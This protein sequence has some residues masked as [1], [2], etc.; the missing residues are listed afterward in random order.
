MV[1]ASSN[2]I[3][4]RLR[5]G[6]PSK[7]GDFHGLALDHSISLLGIVVGGAIAV[8]IVW[9]ATRHKTAVAPPEPVAPPTKLSAARAA[10]STN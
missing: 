2:G 7:Q 6:L 3:S 1:K 5:L 9:L 4:V 8:G 10:A